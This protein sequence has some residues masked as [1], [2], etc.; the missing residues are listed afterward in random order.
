MHTNI[1]SIKILILKLKLIIGYSITDIAKFLNYPIPINIKY[2]KGFAGQ[3]I[4]YYLIGRHINNKYHQD[5]EHLGIE[6]KTITI[7]KNFNVLNDSYICTCSLFK[8]NNM[9]WNTSILYKKLSIILWIPIITNSINTPLKERIIG[10]PK[11]WSPTVDEKKILYKDWYNLIQLLIL[12]QIQELN[13]YYGSI[14]IIKNKSN[15]KQ[16]T[17]FIDYLGNVCYTSPKAFFLKKTFFNNTNF[18]M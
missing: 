11:L 17:K 5:F 10:H 4:E 14:L 12:G 1:H 3:L 7:N 2:N 9:F 6:I 16:N 15:K 18:F 8:N 13:N